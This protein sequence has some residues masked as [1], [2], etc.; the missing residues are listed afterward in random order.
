[1]FLDLY[2]WIV[3]CGLLVYV[4]FNFNGL[5]DLDGMCILFCRFVFSLNSYFGSFWLALDRREE[6]IDGYYIDG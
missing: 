1:M 2:N 6:C 5:F 3:Y 4:G